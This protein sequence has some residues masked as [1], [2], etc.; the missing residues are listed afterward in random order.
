MFQS[1]NLLAMSGK[2]GNGRHT[3]RRGTFARHRERLAACV[4]HILCVYKF[5]I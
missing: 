2:I 4:V 5:E 3:S 1:N